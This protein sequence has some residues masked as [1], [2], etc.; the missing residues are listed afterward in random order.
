MAGATRRSILLAAG[1]FATLLAG[2]AAHQV[3]LR[4]RGRKR[5]IPGTDLAAIPVFDARES[6]ATGHA[7]ARREVM[8]A[9]REACIGE[10]T[11]LARPIVALLDQRARN[12]LAKA[13]PALASE[14]DAIAAIAGVPG[15]YLLNASYEFGCTT[16]AGPAPDG[17]TP[18]LL[19]TLDWPF[20]GLGLHVEI[21]RQKGPAGEFLNITWPGAVGVLTGLATGR[22]AATINQAPF[23]RRSESDWLLP[24]DLV[25][26]T[27]NTWRHVQDEPAMHLLRRVFE[28]ATSYSEALE[29]LKTA[30]IARPAIFTLVGVMPGQSCVIERTVD[31]AFVKSGVATA[32]NDWRYGSFPGLWQGHGGGSGDPRGDSTER[33]A[34]IETFSAKAVPAFEWVRKPILN[35]FTRLAVEMIPATGELR[36]RGFE[37]DDQQES[38]IPVTAT[39]ELRWT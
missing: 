6:G 1:A 36:V 38:A 18:R 2:S 15:I 5:A 31:Q 30:R 37:K 13:S 29:M 19:R 25:R 3:W 27:W 33:N 12:W 34:L 14:L 39:H 20:E 17:K 35:S 23:E 7:Q 16:L 9:L 32:A 21:V 11:P 28:V 24:L 10:L 22:F 26:T 4:Q 8:L